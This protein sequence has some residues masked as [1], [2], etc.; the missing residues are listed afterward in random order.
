MVELIKDKPEEMKECIHLT[1]NTK[2]YNWE[3][4]I[5]PCKCPILDDSGQRTGDY[6]FT[7]METDIDRLARLNNEM[8]RQFGNDE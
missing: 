7:I 5:F 1:K 6:E 2:G 3:L 8:L 4:K